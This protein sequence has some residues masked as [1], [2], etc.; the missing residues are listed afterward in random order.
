M[1]SLSN[2]AAQKLQRLIADGT[3]AFGTALPGQRELAGTL[4]ISRA[5]LRE[6]VSTLEALGLVRSVAGKG[7]FVTA[8]KG[9]DIGE[10]PPNVHGLRPEAI[11]QFRFVLEPAAASMAA[12]NPALDIRELEDIHAQLEAALQRLDLVATAECDMAFHHAIARMSG[13]EAF[14]AV[15]KQCEMH[16]AYSLQLP[17]ANLNRIFETAIEHLHV[18]K[19]ITD[20]Q[21]SAARHAMQSH[22]L[23]AAGRVGIRFSNPDFPA[24]DQ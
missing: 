15:L 24:S 12:A 22:I 6:A 19:S 7:V 20:R 21:P 4:G 8:G 18:I 2:T 13:N 16:V 1:S 10:L 23:H 14:S 5:C 11:F 3:Y 9:R 17:F